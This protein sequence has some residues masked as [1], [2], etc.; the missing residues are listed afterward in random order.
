MKLIKILILI[1]FVY[2]FVN[3]LNCHA[4]WEPLPCASNGGFYIGFVDR[5]GGGG[6]S[7]S[8]GG[9]KC[10]TNDKCISALQCMSICKNSNDSRSSCSSNSDCLKIEQAKCKV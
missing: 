1:A 9:G 2:F 8:V 6:G 4:G 10:Q 3:K 5:G 7:S